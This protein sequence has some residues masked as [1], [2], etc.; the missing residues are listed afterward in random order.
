[1]CELDYEERE[2]VR[3]APLHPPHWHSAV[4]AGELDYVLE[5]ENGIRIARDMRR[6][7]RVK[8]PANYPHL[9]SRRV[10]TAEWVHGRAVYRGPCPVC[11]LPPSLQPALLPRGRREGA[12][13]SV[14]SHLRL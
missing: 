12:V 8:I 9:T 6:L 10:H 13:S 5:C 11:Q 4:E 7:P 3:A 2:C 14:S 1:M